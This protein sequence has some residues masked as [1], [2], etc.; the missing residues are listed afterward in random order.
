MG[1]MP[2]SLQL[3]WTGVGHSISVKL[4]L[5]QERK[6]YLFKK[7][8]H[9]AYLTWPSCSSWNGNSYNL[10]KVKTSRSRQLHISPHR[11]LVFWTAWSSHHISLCFLSMFKSRGVYSIKETELNNSWNNFV[12]K[13]QIF[14]IHNARCVAKMH[15]TKFNFLQYNTNFSFLQCTLAHKR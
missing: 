5:N 8:S 14:H 6:P 9:I 12:F 4:Q 7:C 11:K 2:P 13:T 1:S 3:S 15:I 10:W